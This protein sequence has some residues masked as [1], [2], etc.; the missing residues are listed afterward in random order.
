[1]G[2]SIMGQFF[3]RKVAVEGCH[4]VLGGNAMSGFVKEDGHVLVWATLE[5]CIQ[6]HDFGDGIVGAACVTAYASG[7]T[8]G[9]E[10][11]DRI[12]AELNVG[13]EDGALLIGEGGLGG[14]ELEGLVGA[15]VDWERKIRTHRVFSKDRVN[16]CTNVHDLD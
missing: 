8:C 6:N 2:F 12:S 3:D 4:Q 15:E 14:V 5:E 13:F 10:E 1:M 16:I 7:C 11:H 9:G